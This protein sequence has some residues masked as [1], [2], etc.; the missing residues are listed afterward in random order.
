[1]SKL[2]SFISQPFDF[3]EKAI[4]KGLDQLNDVELVAI[5]LGSG[6]SKHSVLDLSK[7]ILQTCG[8]IRGIIRSD[9]HFL[10]EIPGLGIAKALRLK[11][12]MELGRRIGMLSNEKDLFVENSTQAVDYLRKYLCHLE[13][14]EMWLLALDGRS[15]MIGIRKVSQGGLHGC[16]IM[17]KDVLR[18][19]IRAGANHYIL[20]HNHPSGDPSPSKEDVQ[21]TDQLVKTSQLI[22]VPLADHLILSPNGTYFSMLDQNILCG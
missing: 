1:M 7:E 15:Q 13:H 10:A 22:Q 4:Q 6:T 17:V 12:G 2:F 18:I 3:R 9:I 20:A 8:G 11:S 19:A 14:E 21:L 5:N 16:S